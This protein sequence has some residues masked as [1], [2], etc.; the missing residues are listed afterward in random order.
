MRNTTSMTNHRGKM[1][2]TVK[3][4]DKAPLTFRLYCGK[5]GKRE[6]P[7]DKEAENFSLSEEIFVG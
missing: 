5:S 7:L 2:P 3:F 4:E 6:S 1:S